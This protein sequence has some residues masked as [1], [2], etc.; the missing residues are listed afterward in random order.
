MRTYFIKY[1]RTEEKDYIINVLSEYGIEGHYG[2]YAS[3]N[4]QVTFECKKSVWK[5]IKKKLNLQIES[6]YTSIKV[7]A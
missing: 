4:E 1:Y 2:L 6:V 3:R 5:Q 7:G